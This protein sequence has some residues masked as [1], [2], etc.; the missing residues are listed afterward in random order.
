MMSVE[1]I[2][3][4]ESI[5]SF[6]RRGLLS[7]RELRNAAVPLMQFLRDSGIHIHVRYFP[8]IYE[9]FKDED[10][11]V[12]GSRN[13]QR[14]FYLADPVLMKDHIED[15]EKIVLFAKE[16]DHQQR[17]EEE[18][19]FHQGRILRVWD[20]DRM[21]YQNVTLEEAKQRVYDYSLSSFRVLGAEAEEWARLMVF[22][23]HLYLTGRERKFVS[24]GHYIGSTLKIMLM[25]AKID[26]HRR[27][28]FKAR[29][30]SQPEAV[31]VPKRPRILTREALGEAFDQLDPINQ[32]LVLLRE[33]KVY[34]EQIR[35]M[36]H[37]EFDFDRKV[38]TFRQRYARLCRVYLPRVDEGVVPVQLQQNNLANFLG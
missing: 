17:T 23:S 11:I 5:F 36:I 22:R 35:E 25:H 31:F 14:P 37:S 20:K 32:R 18:R 21:D 38:V 8:I 13:T 33:Q 30:R 6:W 19:L 29:H 16:K 7:N 1:A 2:K 12:C 10:S 26:H 15:I 27:Q 9:H 28:A 34:F 24:L 4:Q 3:P